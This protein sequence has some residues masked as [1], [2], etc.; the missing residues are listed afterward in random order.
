MKYGE[1]RVLRPG[2]RARKRVVER[3]R[4]EWGC[5]ARAERRSP[6]VPP[7]APAC[8]SASPMIIHLPPNEIL[9]A[10]LLAT[11]LM[12][13]AAGVDLPPGDEPRD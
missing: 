4:S 7:L 12:F 5:S 2:G 11:I 1:Q 6:E 13:V 3:A 9:F 8:C 10:L